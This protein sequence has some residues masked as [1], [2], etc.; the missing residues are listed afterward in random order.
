M[1]EYVVP[2]PTECNPQRF[3]LHRDMLIHAVMCWNRALDY[4][5]HLND[6][7]LLDG[8]RYITFEDFEP[9]ELCPFYP[10]TTRDM[11]INPDQ[12]WKPDARVSRALWQRITDYIREIVTIDG[13]FLRDVVGYDLSTEKLWHRG[14]PIK[15]DPE[16][17]ETWQYQSG[18][19]DLLRGM[20]SGRYGP[21]DWLYLNIV[22]QYHRITDYGED[23]VVGVKLYGTSYTYH[24]TRWDS[25]KVVVKQRWRYPATLELEI[26]TTMYFGIPAVAVS[27]RAWTSAYF[28]VSNVWHAFGLANIVPRREFVFI[29]PIVEQYEWNND[30]APINTPWDW[31]LRSSDN[32][33]T[34]S[35]NAFDIVIPN[36]VEII[37]KKRNSQPSIAQ[38]LYRHSDG[39]IEEAPITVRYGSSSQAIKPRAQWQAINFDIVGAIESEHFIYIDFPAQIEFVYDGIV[40]HGDIHRNSVYYFQDHVVARTQEVIGRYATYEYHTRVVYMPRTIFQIFVYR[41]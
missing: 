39:G 2:V 34:S 10:L 22:G 3:L 14:G 21:A 9:A 33:G 35:E 5:E 1:A 8:V 12:Y 13:E 23:E 41:A 28:H 26:S 17:P 15:T 18:D 24:F 40:D 19:Q 16:D 27:S 37:I 6:T 32:S 38:L 20:Q 29:I 30:F 25:R 36:R 11:R 7:V 4:V 31:V